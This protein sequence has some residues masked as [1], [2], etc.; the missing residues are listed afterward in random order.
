MP[1]GQISKTRW[2]IRESSK[3]SDL[4]LFAVGMRK[5]EI[6]TCPAVRFRKLDGKLEKVRK[7]QIYICW[8]SE[9]EGLRFLHNR[10]SDSGN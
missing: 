8:L 4:Y 1:G 9:C 6:F 2:K 10:V 5:A 3:N 7:I